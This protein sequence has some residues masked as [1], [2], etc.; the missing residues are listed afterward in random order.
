MQLKFHILSSAKINK[1]GALSLSTGSNTHG[2]RSR[3]SGGIPG[4]TGCAKDHRT[5]AQH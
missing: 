2:I 5:D 1:N 4:P 3:P